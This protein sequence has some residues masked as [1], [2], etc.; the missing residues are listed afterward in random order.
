MPRKAGYSLSDEIRRALD[1]LVRA[2]DRLREALAEPESN[3]LAI[4]GTIQ[5][6]EFTIELFWKTM[7]RLLARDGVETA[8]PRESLRRAFQAGWIDD[9][10]AWLAMVDVRNRT[11]HAYREALA[12][13]IYQDIRRSFPVMERTLKTLAEIAGR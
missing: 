5:R 6:F 13:G 10:E 8:T 11:S 12:R 3:P 2:V 9:E 1:D 4:D 7:K